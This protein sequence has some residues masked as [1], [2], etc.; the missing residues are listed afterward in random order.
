MTGSDLISVLPVLLPE[1]LLAGGAIALLMYGVFKGNSSTGKVLASGVA[2]LVVA[3]VL[4]MLREDMSGTILADMFLTNDFTRY[5]KMLVLIGSAGAM[6]ISFRYLERVGIA[7][8]EFPV[9]YLFATIGMMMMVSANDLISLYIGLELQSLS[10]YVVA[11]FRRDTLRSTEAGLKYFVLGALSSGMLLYGSSLVYGFVGSTNFSQIATNLATQGGDL[12]LNF[13]L[14]LG[15]VFVAAGLAFKVSAV[16][17]HMWTPDVY[18]GAPLPVTAFFAT[19]P[20]IAA[21]ALLIRVMMEPFG[22]LFNQWQQI[23]V[24]VAVASMLLGAF[25]AIYQTRIKRL[26]AYSSIGHVGFALVG[27]A[28]GTELGIQGLVIYLTIYL[29]MNLGFFAC[30]LSLVKDEAALENL[31][32]FAGLSKTQPFIAAAM[33]IFLFSMAG[34]PPLAGFFSKLYVFIAAVEANLI[35]LAIVGLVTSVFSAFYYIRLIKLMYF[36]DAV[37]G[38]ERVAGREL[39]FVILICAII[40][41]GFILMTSWITGPAGIAAGVY[42]A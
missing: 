3:F 39:Q 2:L 14:I 17:F 26:M 27:L 33:T 16:P 38:V 25:A 9:L 40:T 18:E 10:L 37:E 21:M 19:A 15:L 6:M 30:L 11:A 23:I 22:D 7:K 42:A 1:L 13:G 31:S 24:L 5:M 29:I 4:L 28:A 32:D 36:D 41:I 35:W 34:I 8:F 12:G 20:K